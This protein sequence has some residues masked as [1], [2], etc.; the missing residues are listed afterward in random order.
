M[1]VVILTEDENNYEHSEDDEEAG[2]PKK[3]VYRKLAEVKDVTGN[4]LEQLFVSRK[5]KNF[6]TRFNISLTFLMKPCSQW[7]IDKN[8]LYGKEI[9]SKIKVVN[10]GAERVKV[11]GLLPCIMSIMAWQ[12]TENN[13]NLFYRLLLIIVKTFWMKKK[14]T[15]MS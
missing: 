2:E 7:V 13:N 14:S 8:F 10:K 3:W 1:W 6:F 11:H 9:V 12:R 15:L 5:T 4:G